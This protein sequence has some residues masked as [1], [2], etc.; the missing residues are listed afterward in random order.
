MKKSIYIAHFLPLLLTTLASAEDYQAWSERSYLDEDH[1]FTCNDTLGNIFIETDSQLKWSRQHQSGYIE[2][3]GQYELKDFGGI[4]NMTL[5]IKN[6]TGDHAGIYFCHVFNSTGQL[7]GR[8]V[9][10]LNLAGPL[11]KDYTDEYKWN[12]IVGF[13]SSGCVMALIIGVGLVENFRYLSDEQKQKRK[14][15]KNGKIPR[16]NLAAHQANGID[17]GMMDMDDVSTVSDSKK[18][19]TNGINPFG[20][21]LANT[22]L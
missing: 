13:I 4:A 20:H 12:I 18:E 15:R 2:T 21:D 10:G 7:V 14:D 17:N 11:Y 19:H 22:H 6:V 1:E 9:K 5:L 16:A 3:N 8:A